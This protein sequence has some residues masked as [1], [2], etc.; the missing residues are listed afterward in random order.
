MGMGFESIGGFNA[1]PIFHSLIAARQTTE[2]VF[3][4]KLT[5]NDSELTLGGVNRQ[6]YT[7]DFH[8]VPVTKEGYWQVKFDSLKVGGQKLVGTEACIIDSVCIPRLSA[9]FISN[10]FSREPAL[11]SETLQPSKHSMPRSPMPLKS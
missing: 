10:L 6:L 2:P 4:M 8:Y 9:P 11:S 7:G 5:T 3:A 1:T